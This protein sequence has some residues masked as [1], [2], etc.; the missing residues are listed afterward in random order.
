MKTK[1]ATPTA[2]QTLPTSV[3]ALV[4]RIVSDLD[5]DEV[6]LFGSRARGNHRENSDVD[7][8]VKAARLSKDDWNRLLVAIDEEPL[9]L[10]RVDLVHFE[11]MDADYK[12][13]ISAEGKR[14]YVR[15]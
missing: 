10:H 5:P 9:T 8:A 4:R 2:L 11:E 13:N 7:L 15:P 12:A 14:L 6:I 3:Q 1:A